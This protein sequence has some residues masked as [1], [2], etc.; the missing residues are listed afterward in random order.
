[1]IAFRLFLD[2]TP[3]LAAELSWSLSSVSASDP[4]YAGH[5]ESTGGHQSLV[6]TPASSAHPS[7]RLT[8][9]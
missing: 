3:Y 1:M 2:I 7:R 9:A 5:S 6:E 4:G 8:T